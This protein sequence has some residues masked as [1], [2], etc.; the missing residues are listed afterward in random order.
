MYTFEYVLL[1]LFK[2]NGK[3]LNISNVSVD[4]HLS[5]ASIHLTL[6]GYLP[7]Q[8]LQSLYIFLGLH[9]KAYLQNY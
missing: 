7:A 6:N 2:I 9:P 1:T 4:L 5:L 8:N 3:R